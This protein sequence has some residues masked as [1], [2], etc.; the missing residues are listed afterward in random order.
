[1]PAYHLLRLFYR[2][3]RSDRLAQLFGHAL[4]PELLFKVQGPLLTH[5]SPENKLGELRK[6]FVLTL[7]LLL[8]DLVGDGIAE[9]VQAHSAGGQGLL[10]ALT[11][12]ASAYLS[13]II[14]A[15]FS[16]IVLTR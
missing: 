5:T 7:K 1:M 6:A 13:S 4:L 11:R 16:Q 3:P 15:A 12:A 8:E 10:Y 14:R 9:P 2:Q